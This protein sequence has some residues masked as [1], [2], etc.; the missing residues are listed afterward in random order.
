MNASAGAGVHQYG[1]TAT[2]SH[3]QIWFAVTVEV[4][5]GQRTPSSVVGDRHLKGAVAIA[6]QHRD[7]ASDCNQIELA[8]AIEVAYCDR[9]TS[10]E[11]SDGGLETAIAVAHQYC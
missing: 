10:T 6:Q 11:V 1:D 7:D 5:D 2:D 8:I 9:R 3:G 4:T